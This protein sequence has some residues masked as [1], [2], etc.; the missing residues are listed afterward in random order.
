MI[1][2]C[3]RVFGIPPERVRC[4]STNTTRIAN[5]SP[6]A[7]S[8]T[9]DLNGNA[10]ILACEEILEGMDAIAAKELDCAPDDLDPRFAG[11]LQG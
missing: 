6:S 9:S 3:S 7:A 10:T 8:A 2:I 4:N 5:I 1:A 11:A